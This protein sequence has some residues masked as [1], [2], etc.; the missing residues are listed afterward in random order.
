MIETLSA[1]FR[2]QPRRGA[3]AESQW[4]QPWFGKK[5][6]AI[7]YQGKGHCISDPV[8]QLGTGQL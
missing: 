2:N 7:G 4:T 3:G 1:F 6:R 8:I 5:Y